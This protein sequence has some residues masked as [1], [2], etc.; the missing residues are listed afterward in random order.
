MHSDENTGPFLQRTSTPV[1]M[2][3]KN[4]NESNAINY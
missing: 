1:G 2:I 3:A 4:V